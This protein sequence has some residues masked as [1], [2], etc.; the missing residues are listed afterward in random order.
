MRSL[1]KP[2]VFIA[3][4]EFDNLGTGYLCA[5]L[6]KN[7][8]ET[9]VIDLRYNNYQILNLIKR[10]NPVIIGFSVIFDLYIKKFQKLAEL[11]RRGGIRCHFTAGGHYATLRYKELFHLI[12][13]LDSIVRFD[14]EYTILELTQCI[15]SGLEWRNIKSIVYKSRGRIISNTLRPLEKDLDNYPFPMR[16]PLKD[17][18]FGKKYAAVLAGRGCVYNCSYCCLREYYS[19]V[20]G[21]VKRIR[22]PE[23]VTR[24]MELLSREKNC[25]VFLFQDDDF[26]IK[27]GK[28]SDWIKTFCKELTHRKLN[29]KIMWKI[30]CRPDEIREEIIEMMKL[31]GLFLIFIGI[32]DGTDSGLS[33]L[34]KQMTV[35]ECLKGISIL[36]KYE[37]DF[38]FGFMLFQPSSTFVSINEN[39]DFL[40]MICSDGSTPVMFNKLLPYFETAVEKELRKEGRLMG[41]HDFPDYKFCEEA[42]NR[43]Y[44]FI[45]ECFSEWL[46]DAGGIVNISR[47]ARIYYSVYSRYYALSPE[48]HSIN[49]RIRKVIAESNSFIL[50]TMKELAQL[51]ESYENSSGMNSMLRNY[52]K[53]IN[54]HYKDYVEQIKRTVSDMIKIEEVNRI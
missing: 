5:I 27:A 51:F 35:A 44:D 7:G 9:K 33:R 26:P 16:F 49:I 42:M 10:L 25:S 3:F 48:A 24:E 14:G 29:D 45:Y 30:N 20:P 38:D 4:E 8:Y 11:L 6:S 32:E 2:V 52:R 37:I 40:K 15:T 19:Q 36:K 43:Y 47:W 23:N 46:N 50:N 41:T 54:S 13:F 31:N 28:D 18:A 17:Y 21:P 12:P 1:C 39:L 22:N 53:S 34:N